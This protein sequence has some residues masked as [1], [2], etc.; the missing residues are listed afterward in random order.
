MGDT[1]MAVLAHME[2]GIAVARF[3]LGPQGLRIG[4][5]PDNDVVVDDAL[6]SKA[7]AVV[8]ACSGD[9]EAWQVRDLDSTNHTWLNG[10]Q[11]ATQVLQHN[12]EIVV[13]M[14]ELRFLDES[15]ALEATQEVRK[16]W[17]PG[18]YYTRPKK[19]D[20]NDAGE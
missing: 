9:S 10:S 6:V 3:E 2:G 20:E 16:S 17:I 19:E 7:H 8:E 12:D 14:C 11:V 5:S 4:R 15:Q 13:G 1:G 18:L